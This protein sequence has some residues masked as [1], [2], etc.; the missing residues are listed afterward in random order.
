MKKENFTCNSSILDQKMRQPSTQSSFLSKAIQVFKKDGNSKNSFLGEHS[1]FQAGMNS[2]GANVFIADQDLNLVY[3]N[4]KAEKT[5]KT[6]KK[7]IFEAFKVPVADLLGESIHRFHKNPQD[8]EKI[9]RNP[10]A[11]PHDATFTFGDV[12]L[13]TN[14]NG[15]L[16]DEGQIVGHIVNWEEVSDQIKL[17]D[18]ASRIGSMMENAPFNV[19]F[20]DPE[21]NLRYLNPASIKTLKTSGRCSTC[22]SR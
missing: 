15:I 18:E 1:A 19:M 9:L 12:S 8:V 22:Q 2:L 21:L 6:I 10:L 7:D 11:L 13:R 3:M 17:K 14:I 16:G 20:A 4:S 5:L